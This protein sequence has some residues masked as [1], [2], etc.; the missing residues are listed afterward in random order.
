MAIST[1]SGIQIINTQS[2]T[3]LESINT[4]RE[5]K[6]IAHNNGS[7]IYCVK[8]K[9]IQCIQISNKAITILVKDHENID[10][11]GISVHGTKIYCT[12]FDYSVVNCYTLKGNHMWKFQ[13]TNVLLRPTGIALDNNS[14]VYVASYYC[15]SVIVLSS[16][17]R[18]FKK[19]LSLKDGLFKPRALHVDKKNNTLLVANIEQPTYLYHISHPDFVFIWCFFKL[20]LF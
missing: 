20:C 18:K 19:L 12:D 17:G 3:V 9:G 6:R 2:G 5:C 15:N 4:D 8:S 14:N 13:N 11:L 10:Q 7:L 1:S 16:D